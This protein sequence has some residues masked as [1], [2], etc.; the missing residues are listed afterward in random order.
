MG[1]GPLRHAGE[2]RQQGE[3]AR[4][5]NWTLKVDTRANGMRCGFF[6]HNNKKKKNRKRGKCLFEW[7]WG[8]IL[9]HVNHPHLS[10]TM[11]SIKIADH[12]ISSECL[13]ATVCRPCHFFGARPHLNS[14]L[15]T[16][17]PVSPSHGSVSADYR[18]TS[19]PTEASTEH[20]RTRAS[21][22]T[23]P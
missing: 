1:P 5:L 13:N 19:C 4:Q 10:A 14:G 2:G 15:R 8:L 11:S 16:D 18:T 20:C 9:S 22:R 6:Y 23:T 12:V 3:G 7:G 17:A 21:S